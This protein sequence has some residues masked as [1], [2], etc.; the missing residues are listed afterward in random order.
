MCSDQFHSITGLLPA[1]WIGRKT[2]SG[3]SRIALFAIILII[4]CKCSSKATF[5]GVTILLSLTVFLL[6]VAESMP[7][8]SDAIPLIGKQSPFCCFCWRA[9]PMRQR[10]SITPLISYSVTNNYYYKLTK[11]YFNSKVYQKKLMISQNIFSSC[12]KVE[13]C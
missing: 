5:L 12:T 6:L 7:A 11:F 4:Q 13:R 1:S 10:P 2:D 9:F 3:Y 8:T